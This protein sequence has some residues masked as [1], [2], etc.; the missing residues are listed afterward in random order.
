[1]PDLLEELD[2]LFLNFRESHSES[3]FELLVKAFQRPIAALMRRYLSEFSREELEDAIA[4]YFLWVFEYAPLL[5]NPAY[6]TTPSQFLYIYASYQARDLRRKLS[7]KASSQVSL[8]EQLE[9]NSTD[10]GGVFQLADVFGLEELVLAKD[11]ILGL[12]EQLTTLEKN[13]AYLSGQGL[14]DREIAAQLGMTDTNVR[15]IRFRIRKKLR[16]QLNLK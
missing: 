3:D 7:R 6:E 2:Q 13:V 10:P 9:I 8:D 4:N 5:Y 15:Q 11:S 14:K 1:M 16:E 12:W